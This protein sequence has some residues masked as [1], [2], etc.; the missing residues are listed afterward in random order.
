MPLYM[1]QFAYTSEAWAAL[2]KKPENRAEAVSALA[3]KMGGR[4][5]D[6]YYCFGEYDG[7]IL[8]DLPTDTAA[9]AFV[10]AGVSGGHIKANR[11][12]RLMTVNE[13]MEAMKQ[14][15]STTI[16]APGA[17]TAAAAGRR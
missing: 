5:V 15:G 17:T 2:T 10:L 8:V 13:A 12:T 9:T 4:L 11:T 6:M 14:A 3:Q 1:I 16:A 7:V